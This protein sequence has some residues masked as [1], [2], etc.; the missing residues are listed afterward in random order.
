MLMFV[1][2]KYWHYEYTTVYAIILNAI[3]TLHKLS[4]NF[5]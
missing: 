4:E 5:S 3:L 2:V 1:Q